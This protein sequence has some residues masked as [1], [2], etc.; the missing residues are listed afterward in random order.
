M[1]DLSNGS[2]SA[3]L[4]ESLGKAAPSGIAIIAGH[5][6]GQ[7]VEELRSAGCWA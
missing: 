3:Q 5:K 6:G 1:C 2:K 4:P 7:G